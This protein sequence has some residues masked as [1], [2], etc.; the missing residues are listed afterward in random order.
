MG[1]G[2]GFPDRIAASRIAMVELQLRG[3]GIRDQRV[4]E[5][6]AKVPRHLFVAPAFAGN[7]YDDQ[8]LPIGEGQTVSQPYIVAA[9]LESLSLKPSDKVLE[10]GTGSGYQTALLA[11][12]VA[13]VFGIERHA[14]LTLSAQQVLERLG[15]KNVQL[16]TGD[17]SLGWPEA[18]P[19]D[20][21]IISAAAPQIP[22]SLIAQL[23][24]GGRMIAPVGTP[25]LQELR[26]VRRVGEEIRS[27]RLDGCR[28]VPLVGEQGFTS[29]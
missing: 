10:I 1:N 16:R 23:K 22:P 25:E 27:L 19:F 29:S 3:R 5:A 13:E 7:A 2:N 18:A 15:Y 9:M 17:G 4:L 11:E 8:P 12:L 26:L 20:G 14:S 21:I 6:M 24:D 28:F